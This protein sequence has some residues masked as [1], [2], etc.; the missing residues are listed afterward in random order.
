MVCSSS[1]GHRNTCPLEDSN[2]RP[3]CMAV[4][5]E[6]NYMMPGYKGINAGVR[7][8]KYRGTVPGD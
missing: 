6:N 3:E 5:R 1:H 4:I 7:K 2:T 8:D